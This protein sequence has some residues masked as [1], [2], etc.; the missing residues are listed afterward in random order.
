VSNPTAAIIDYGLGN[1]YSVQQAC[2]KVGIESN[3]TADRTAIEAADAVILPGMGAFGDAMD[4]LRRLDLVHLL[5]DLAAA[6]KP[7]FGVCLGLQLF[8]SESCEFG[9]HEGL[10]LIEGDVIRFES[11]VET[12]L[13]DGKPRDFNLKVPLIGWTPICEARSWDGTVLEHV[14]PGASMYFVHSFYVRP[15]DPSAVLSTSHYGHI[16]FCSSLQKDNLFACQFHPERSGAE[17]LK[18]YRQF[19]QLLTQRKLHG[20]GDS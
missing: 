16:E 19:A 7:M 11:P 2:G 8:M 10:N 3:I 13:I 1:L 15:T 6:G 9:R 14:T 12:R 4:H 17:G 5:R 20:V 18:I